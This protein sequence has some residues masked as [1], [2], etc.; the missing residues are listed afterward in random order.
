M[1]LQTSD[2]FSS[3]SILMTEQ[4]KTKKQL[5]FHFISQWRH[6]YATSPE[7]HSDLTFESND[8]DIVIFNETDAPVPA[9]FTMLKIEGYLEVA[10]V[11]HQET[12][13][14]ITSFCC[15]CWCTKFSA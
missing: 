12:T 2:C 1:I 7:K 13:T 11:Y 10:P 8:F 4:T 6:L 14:K 15:V 5:P 9:D 3:L